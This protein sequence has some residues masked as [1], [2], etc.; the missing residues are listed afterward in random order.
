[1]GKNIFTCLMIV[2][3][4]VGCKD[5]SK[6]NGS[7]SNAAISKNKSFKQDFTEENYKFQIAYDHRLDSSFLDVSFRG[8]TILRDRYRGVVTDHILSDLDQDR[9][10]EIFFVVD[11]EE[12][13]GLYGISLDIRN[14]EEIQLIRRIENSRVLSPKYSLERN[15]I[16]ERYNIIAK[17]GKERKGEARYNMVER[18]NALVLL[19]QGWQEYE[20]KNLLGQY[21]VEDSKA[22]G[23][24]KVLLI[25]E[26][27]GGQWNVDI[28]VKRK[29]DNKQVCHFEGLGE[30]INRDLLVSLNQKNENLKGELQIRFVNALATVYTSDKA[31]YKEMATFCTSEG[32]IVGNY[33]RQMNE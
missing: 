6:T 25:G 27:E 30:F 20:L 9:N 13:S 8:Q 24:R 5:Q 17:D 21:V 2:M 32:S 18:N 22:D 1:M 28:K 10:K 12:Q 23:F 33:K 14:I 16:I 11:D 26:R 19:P 29:K 7:N 15:Q 3:I 4:L 31:D